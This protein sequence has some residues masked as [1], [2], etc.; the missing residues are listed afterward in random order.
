MKKLFFKV[1]NKLRWIL[2]HWR[3]K[4]QLRY[5]SPDAVQ[6]PLG[7]SIGIA[8][9]MDRYESCLVPLV[10]KLAFLF[11]A[12]EIIV[13]ANGHVKQREQR[14]YLSEIAAFCRLY[15]NVR[16]IAHQQP[17]GLSAIWNETILSSQSEQ[18]LLLNDDV[19][20]KTDFGRFLRQAPCQR[21]QLVL[22]N[23]SWSHFMIS[24]ALFEA[25]GPFDEGLK[26]IGGED[27]DYAARL[28]MQSIAI[29]HLPTHSITSKL[30]IH[31]KK[32][33]VN[34]YGRNMHEEAN[35]Y[36][37]YNA[38]YLEAKWMMSDQPFE[39]AVYVPRR[40]FKYWKLRNAS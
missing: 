19:D 28:A 27:D 40:A 29:C 24:K 37:S 8:T 32:L 38:D 16:L 33:G 6:P 30:K 3:W 35:G 11:P 31:Q 25:V 7:V 1:V 39:G 22:F 26:E 9:F 36:S 34:S 4:F 5:A 15:P 23:S 21:Q 18:V 12:A 17:R 2:D 13:V 14:E 20:V 10:R